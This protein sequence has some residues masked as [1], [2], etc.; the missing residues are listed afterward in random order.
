MMLKSGFDMKKLLA[1]V[2]PGY[3]MLIL[4][5]AFVL[6]VWGIAFG[7][8]LLETRPDE[9]TSISIA[10]DV[11]SGEFN[12][13]FF[14]YPSLH[15]YLL[16]FLYLIYYAIGR[17]AGTFKTLVDLAVEFS[18][19]PT[20][21]HL[22]A[23]LMSVV[24]AVATIY[25]LY[26]LTKRLLNS[27]PAALI[28]SLLLSIAYLHVRESHFAKTD[29][30]MVFFLVLSFVFIF[31]LYSR[32]SLR[33]SLL[34]GLASGLAISSK[35]SAF[36]VLASLF[37]VYVLYY[38]KRGLPIFHVF[39]NRN[40]RYSC[41]AAFFGFILGTPYS[42]LSSSEF[43]DG[44]RFLSKSVNEGYLG[45]RTGTGW[46]FHLRYSLFYGIGWSFYLAAAVGTVMLFVRDWRK[47]VVLFSFPLLYY[48]FIGRSTLRAVRFV[49]PLVPFLCISASYFFDR[50]A[51]R[52]H[53]LVGVFS[54]RVILTLTLAILAVPSTLS[55]LRFN[56]LLSKEDSRLIARSWIQQ[57]LATGSSVYQAGSLPGRIQLA[58]PLEFLRKQHAWFLDQGM[59]LE[60]ELAQA[61]I[62]HLESRDEKGFYPWQYDQ[63]QDRFSFAGVQQDT[64][65][66]YIILIKT[67]VLLDQHLWP[68]PEDIFTHV[69]N[70]YVLL[71]SF[72]PIDFNNSQDFYDQ[73]DAY[74]VPFAG[75]HA[76][77]RPGPNVYIYEWKEISG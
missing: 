40:L 56:R 71:R 16:S 12:P 19:D 30:M 29:V 2:A 42:V 38:L 54:R 21:L 15:I 62:T 36:P 69:E 33:D 32:Q 28:S 39:R 60:A 18:L 1:Q 65:P 58:L 5:L 7:L 64:I 34:A 72:E 11:L 53:P 75:L 52:L 45:F 74:Y 17:I 44:I 14:V 41:V 68:I 50:F 51:H 24:F 47:S 63:I 10:L 3:L 67:P 59:R 77:E 48:L 20:I 46:W 66:Q 9:L 27:E 61:M 22:I 70:E 4:I 49:L 43:L 37:L 73:T 76:I 23:R 13:H 6:R 25:L 35:Y 57:Q 26:R 55:S 8:P 31:K